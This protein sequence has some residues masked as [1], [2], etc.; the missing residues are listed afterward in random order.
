MLKSIVAAA[1]LAGLVAG[2]L[3]TA[4]QQIE[5]EPLIG[6]AEAREASH[7]VAAGAGNQNAAAWAPHEGPERLTATAIANVVLATAYAL[8]LGA[9]MSLRRHLGWRT[10]VL[11]GIAGY[12]VFFVSPALGLPPQLPGND[13][14]PLA[15]RQIWWIG[16]ASCAAAGL[17]LAAFAR[18]PGWRMLGL[19]LVIVPHVVGAPLSMGSG[20]EDSRAFIRATYVTN[21]ALWLMLGVLMG[22]IGKR[23]V[24]ARR[25][26]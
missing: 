6:A 1:A 3:L 19:A 11:W 20:H 12:V 7:A 16:A 15:D 24:V 9:A 4:V 17:W 8:L 13:A 14:A 2:L 10:G 26:P 22:G 25:S 5:V 18:R 21:A 23:A